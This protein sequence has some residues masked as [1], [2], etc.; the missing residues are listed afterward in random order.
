MGQRGGVG[1][2]VERRG[3]SA[4]FQCCIEG[5]VYG[6]LGLVVFGSGASGDMCF[7]GENRFEIRVRA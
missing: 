4:G 7:H 2:R 1:T 5:F 6:K 3:S